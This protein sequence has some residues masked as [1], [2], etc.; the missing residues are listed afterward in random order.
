[1]YKVKRLIKGMFK[2]NPYLAPIINQSR[3]FNSYLTIAEIVQVIFQLAIA[4]RTNQNGVNIQFMIQAC[5]AIGSCLYVHVNCR[6]PYFKTSIKLLIGAQAYMILL[7]YA[8][9]VRFIALNNTCIKI[10]TYYDKLE[11]ATEAKA[12]GPC[13]F[14]RIVY[15]VWFAICVGITVFRLI[16]FQFM[17]RAEK[18]LTRKLREKQKRKIYRM[19]RRKKEKRMRK[20]RIL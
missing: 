13:T 11:P 8:I 6:L 4:G 3:I 18:F 12:S 15:F 14:T 5:I 17:F 16:G 9:I 20:F 2:P 7:V 1:M 19:I 10:F